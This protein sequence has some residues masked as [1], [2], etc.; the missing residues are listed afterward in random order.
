MILSSLVFYVDLYGNCRRG[1][2]GQPARSAHG[3]AACLGRQE[4]FRIC[5]EER[6]AASD[7]GTSQSS[8]LCTCTVF[9]RWKASVLSL[10]ME[11]RLTEDTCLPTY[12]QESWGNES[13]ADSAFSVTQIF[14]RLLIHLKALILPSNP[15]SRCDYNHHHF[16]QEVAEAPRG[17][18]LTVT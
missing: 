6:K 11:L 2:R 10:Q 12:K 1:Q 14:L 5:P 15:L 8:V 4:T 17:S 9:P 18:R 16:I 3:L 13:N 7:H